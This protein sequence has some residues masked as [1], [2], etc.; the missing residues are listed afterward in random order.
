MFFV[1]VAY[2]FFKI[3]TEVFQIFLINVMDVSKTDYRKICSAFKIIAKS[4]TL[5]KF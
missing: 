2:Q 3:L 1:F 5:F 4:M